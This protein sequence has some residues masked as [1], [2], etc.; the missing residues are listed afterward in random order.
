MTVQEMERMS[1]CYC[2]ELWVGTIIKTFSIALTI[3]FGQR[4][5]CLLFHVEV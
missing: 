4:K 2:Q 1:F 3:P 5:S